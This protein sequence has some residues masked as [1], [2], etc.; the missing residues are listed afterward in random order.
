MNLCRYARQRLGLSMRAFAE[1]T[2]ASQSAIARREYGQV[3]ISGLPESLYRLILECD[4]LDLN[5]EV[6]KACESIP[7]DLRSEDRA[8]MAIMLTCSERGKVDVVRRAM[9]DASAT[10]KPADVS[11]RYTIEKMRLFGQG[12]EERAKRAP[13][14]ASQRYRDA[15][16]KL[17]SVIY[18]IERGAELE[19]SEQDEGSEDTE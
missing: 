17:A 9:G 15:A 3:E 5:Q 16:S 13:G 2:G 1:L 10:E 7:K 18:D 4:S 11:A 19:R 6:L 12:L 8:L 14:E